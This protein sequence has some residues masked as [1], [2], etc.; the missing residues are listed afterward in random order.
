MNR[1]RNLGGNSG[2]AGYQINTTSITIQFSGNYK[3]YTYSYGKAGQVHVDNMKVLATQG[4]GLNAYIKKH[5]N[6]LYD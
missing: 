5:V 3:L 2:V 1:Y 4:R 6:N